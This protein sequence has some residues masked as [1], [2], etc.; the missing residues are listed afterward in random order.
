MTPLAAR[1]TAQLLAGEAAG[2]AVAVAERLLAVQAQDPRGAR[3][4]VRARTLGSGTTA[5]G[6]DRALTEDRSLV[7][8]WLN[9]GTLHL[10]RRE[11]WPWLHALTTPPLAA[12]SARRLAQEGVPPDDADRSCTCCWPR[13]CA[14]AS[15][16]ARPPGPDTRSRSRATG[17][18]RRSGGSPSAIAPRSDATPPTSRAS[19][20]PENLTAAGF[21]HLRSGVLPDERT[22]RPCEA[23]ATMS[24]EEQGRMQEVLGAGARRRAARAADRP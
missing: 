13:R 15:Y 22:V 8:S 1:L 21:P 23:R 19:S 14:S 11:D 5:A 10:V 9:R 24:D 3:L 16:V 18:W 20:A 2:D 4:A 17:S 12:G 7:V 6:V